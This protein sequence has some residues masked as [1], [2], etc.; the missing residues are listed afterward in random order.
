MLQVLA[1]LTIAKGKF[2]ISSCFEI[3]RPSDTIGGSLMYFVRFE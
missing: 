2:R 3:Q 1:M